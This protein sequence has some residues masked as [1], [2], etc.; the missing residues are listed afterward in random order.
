MSESGP[1]TAAGTAD[2]EAGKAGTADVGDM[3]AAREAILLAA[4]PNVPFDGWSTELLRR[5]T[6]QAGFTRDVGRIAFPQGVMDLVDY[7]S[8]WADREMERRLK[9]HDLMEMRIRDKIALAVRLRLEALEPSRDAARRAAG[10]FLAPPNGLLGAK[11]LYRTVDAMWRGIGDTSTDFNFY[12]KRATLSGVV[13][14]TMLHWFDDRS[15]GFADTWAFLDRRIENVMQFEKVKARMTKATEGMPD[16]FEIL[17]KL[18]YPQPRRR[19]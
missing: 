6:T 12:T 14:S 15:E 8:D 16:P 19:D 10:A 5:A 2:P 3:D 1:D 18:R 7:Y 17:G 9:E 11:C 13:A 4:L